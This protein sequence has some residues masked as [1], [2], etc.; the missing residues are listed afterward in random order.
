MKMSVVLYVKVLYVSLVKSGKNTRQQR[1]CTPVW[2]LRPGKKI[3]MQD[4]P[5]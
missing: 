3:Y 2:P 5:Q 4:Y 1:R